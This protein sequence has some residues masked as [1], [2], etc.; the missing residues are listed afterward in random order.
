MY[1]GAYNVQ[2]GDGGGDRGEKE[3]KGRIPH[4]WSPVSPSPC[5][6]PVG[7]LILG[8]KWKYIGM[9]TT[10]YTRSARLGLDGFM[11]VVCQDGCINGLWTN[12]NLEG[13]RQILPRTALPCGV[14]V[15]TH[16]NI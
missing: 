10:T 4:C 9:Y 11:C 6:L 1:V 2:S 8:G 14:H 5:D 7:Q 13:P 3:K 15:Y 12:N 16:A